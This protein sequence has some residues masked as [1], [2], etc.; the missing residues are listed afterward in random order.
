LNVPTEKISVIPLGLTISATTERLTET[1]LKELGIST[2][3][4]FCL[5]AVDPRKNTDLTV[6]TFLDSPVAKDSLL[7]LAGLDSSSREALLARVA[8]HSNARS[9]VALEF[10]SDEQL[11]RLYSSCIAFIFPSLYEGF[12][13]PVLEAMNCGA[14]VLCSNLTSVPEVGGDAVLYFNPRSPDEL[15]EGLVNLRCNETLRARLSAASLERAKQFCWER[16]AEDL[17]TVLRAAAR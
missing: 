7:V 9:L 14:P 11:A 1:Q 5:G 3:F 13:L 12:G 6:D 16:S 10:I 17:L 4:F 8:S 2:P 15:S